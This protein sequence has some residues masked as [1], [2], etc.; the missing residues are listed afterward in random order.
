MNTVTI[1][2][3]QLPAVEYRGQR[4]VTM[5]MIDEAHDRPEGTAKDA[6]NRNRTRFVEGVDTYLIDYSEK[7]VLHPFGIDVPFRG[8]R[9]F[10]ETGYLMLTKPFNDD[11]A[12]Q[13]QRELVNNYFRHHRSKS[14]AEII[15][16][17]ELL[18][19]E[20]ER[21]LNHVEDKVI[22]VAQTVESIKRG[23]LPAGW[24]GYSSLKA[25]LGMTPLKCKTLINAYGVPTDTHEYLTPDGLLA[26][27]EIVEYEPFMH[28]LRLVMAE[29][30][31]KGA[32][33]YHPK[34]NLF[35]VLNWE[36]K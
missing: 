18:N 11:L 31:Q 5:A 12:W 23:S 7:N 26:K 36:N 22:E 28:A 14:Q 33:W 10:T 3:K 16:E 30:E 24:I 17:M 15:A 32:R 19:V 21:R 35:Q 8:L 4:I 34:M 9:V 6:F 25:K 1:N 20:Q 29:A 13:V 27:R 2:N